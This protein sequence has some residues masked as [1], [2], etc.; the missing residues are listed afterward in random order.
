LSQYYYF[1]LSTSLSFKSA[2]DQAASKLYFEASSR[3]D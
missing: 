1:Q 2:V 3:L